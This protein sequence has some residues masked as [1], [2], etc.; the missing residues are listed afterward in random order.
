MDSWP[1]H[2]S[3]DYLYKGRRQPNFF[4]L[5]VEHLI[6]SNFL[7]TTH[8]QITQPITHAQ[9]TQPPKTEISYN[10]RWLII[11]YIWGTIQMNWL[12]LMPDLCMYLLNSSPA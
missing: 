11:I 6:W 2:D 3:Y 1:K 8:H 10:M 5:H 4:S 12:E 9:I 7:Q